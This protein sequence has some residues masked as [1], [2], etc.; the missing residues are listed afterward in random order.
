MT[1]K[2]PLPRAAAPLRLVLAALL[3]LAGLAA[4]LPATAG[5]ST[6]AAAQE[7][8]GLL[9]MLFGGGLRRSEPKPP[10]RAREPVRRERPAARSTRRQ[11]APAASPAPAASEKL[12]NAREVLVVGDF[13]AGGLAEGLETAYAESPGVLIVD[14]TNGSSGFVRDDFYDWNANIGPILDEVEPAAVVVMIGSNDRQ[15][16]VVDGQRESPRSEDWTREYKRRAAALADAVRERGIPLIWTGLPPF[17]SSSMSS[18]MLAF[19][20]IHKRVA[21]AA[22]GEFVDIWEGFV[23]ESG[24][25]V[26]SGPD[27]NGQPVRLRAG[28]GINVTRPG[29]RKIAFYV[30]RPLNKVLGDAVSPDIG[31]LGIEN[32]PTLEL[33]PAGPPT[34]DRTAPISLLDAELDGG[35]DLLG[36]EVAPRRE[37]PRTP[38]ERLAIEGLAPPP[39]PGRADDFLID[40]AGDEAPREPQ[41]PPDS[42]ETG[43]IAR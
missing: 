19:N 22:G 11:S 10:P 15:Q 39:K 24:N 23:D 5:L 36:G 6:E 28:D 21:E 20:D 17:R 25:F 40:G 4:A 32:L 31:T 14:R 1:P 33:A 29:R 2:T 8:R 9:D 18:D 42:A 30:E 34:I 16:M 26:Y 38:A 35:N 7:R 41:S 13:L 43:A 27:M 37:A 12:D 3:C